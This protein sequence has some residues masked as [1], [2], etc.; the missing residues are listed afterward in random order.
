M[1]D[2]DRAR[3]FAALHAR[4]IDRVRLGRLLDGEPGERVVA[5]LAPYANADGG[6][7]HALEPDVRTSASQPIAVLTALELLHE[8]GVT[9]T[10]LVDASLEWLQRVT[11][12]D[13]GIPFSPG[14]V[15]D[16]PHAPWMAPTE[17]DPSS[18]HMTLAVT[19]AAARVA[20]GHPWVER[21]AGFCREALTALDAPRAHETLYALHFADALGDEAVLERVATAIP[22][23]GRLPV[24]GG[25]EGETLGLLSLS[26]AP[27][28]VSRRLF[29]EDAV[30]ADLDRLEAAQHADGGWD[31]DFLKWNPSAA[32]EW[33]GRVT[34]D[35]LVLLR[36][37]G[38]L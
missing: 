22:P 8:A 14:T 7:A 3:E 6:F 11:N 2:L 13:G 28:R 23:D 25:V 20:P 37:N 34:V 12:D 18:L 33:R 30:A 10:P 35:A 26:P 17:G 24:P 5:A 9:Q 38:R 21:A 16:A 1:I 15:A 19:A 4:L 27:D 31:V 36:A 29:T 32:W